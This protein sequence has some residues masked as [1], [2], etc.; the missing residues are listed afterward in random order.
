MQLSQLRS[1]G[2]VE[3][4]RSGQ[5]GLYRLTQS[6]QSEPFV[7]GV[8][9]RAGAEIVEAAQDDK[10]LGLILGK[11]KEHLQGYFDGLGRQIW[12]KL[13]AR[14]KLESACRDAAQAAATYENSRSWRG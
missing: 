11:R 5:K 9:D 7:V 1:A 8:L 10:A 13:C 6:A 2:F 14:P 12:K 4:R 3:V